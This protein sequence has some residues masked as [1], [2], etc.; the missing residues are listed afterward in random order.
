ML[1]VRKELEISKE[2]RN[3]KIT[4]RT[5]WC[6]CCCYYY[7]YYYYYC[8]LVYCSLSFLISLFFWGLSKFHL[9]DYEHVLGINNYDGASNGEYLEYLTN[10]FIFCH[11]EQQQKKAEIKI[12]CKKK[13]FIQQQK[14]KI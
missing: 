5:F 6:L 2:R 3:K 8:F 1:R 9:L 4:R 7:Y 13:K 10:Y 12:K 11:F 14:K